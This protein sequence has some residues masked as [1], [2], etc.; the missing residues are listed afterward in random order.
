MVKNRGRSLLATHLWG[1]TNGWMIMMTTNKISKS[2]VFQVIML[3][4][5]VHEYQHFRELAASIFE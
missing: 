2:Q 3:Y 5:L 1:N 4:G